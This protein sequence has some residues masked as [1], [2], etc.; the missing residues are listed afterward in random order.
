MISFRFGIAGASDFFQYAGSVVFRFII[1][2]CLALTS[3]S[4]SVYAA[5]GFD[6]AKAR[7]IV[8]TQ[9]ASCHG[10]DTKTPSDAS[11][12]K[13]AGQHEDYLYQAMIAYQTGSRKNALMQQQMESKRLSQQD[14][15]NLAYYIS[16][17]PSDLKN[18]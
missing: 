11:I 3:L 14:L 1:L 6:L 12:P 17:L 9:C 5:D 4:T 18:R 15:H 13:L 7:K 16:R 8:V 10:I 2:S